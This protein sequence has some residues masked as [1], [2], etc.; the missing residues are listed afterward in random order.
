MKLLRRFYPVVAFFGG[1]IVDALTL[2]QRVKASD[3]WQLGAY[4]LGAAVFASWLAWRDAREKEPP[5]PAQNLKGHAARLVWQAPYLLVQ[6]FYGSIFSALFILYFKSSG[7]L[8]SWFTAAVLGGLLVANEF[9]GDRYGRRFTLTWSLFALNAILLLNFVLPHLAGS[10][11]PA[12]FYISTVAGAVLAHALR[13]LAPGRPGRIGPAW[14]IAAA[15]LV[16]WSLGMI[17]PVPLVK[18]DMAVGH[19]FL[20]TPGRFVLNVEEPPWWQFWRDESS[21][22]HV[23][24]GGRLYG[25]TA[26]FAPLGVTANLEHRW[27]VW[28]DKAW[29]LVYRDRFRSTGGRE[30]GFRGYSWVLN[31]K[32]GDWRFTVGTQDGRTIGVLHV[33]VERGDPRLELR[34]EREF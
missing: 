27:E 21:V 14:G 29:K 17:A 24:E 32:P 6:F 19:D 11:D 8:G 13:W 12:W 22:A 31:P 2:G 25:V 33:R 5:L 26:I 9:A 15:L 28:E 16:A 3:F 20:R 1:F 4:L 7:N 18:R 30:R 10:L 34:A 23:P